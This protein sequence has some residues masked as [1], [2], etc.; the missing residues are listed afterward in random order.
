MT[1]MKLSQRDTEQ[2]HI[3]QLFNSVP[4]EF[5]SRYFVSLDDDN[6]DCK[7]ITGGPIVTVATDE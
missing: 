4:P 1:W 5:R 7:A 2:I 6:D 3:N